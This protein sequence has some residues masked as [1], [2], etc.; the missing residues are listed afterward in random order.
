MARAALTMPDAVAL[1]YIAEVHG[2]GI[3]ICCS[4]L[5]PLHRALYACKDE[6]RYTFEVYERSAS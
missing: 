6:E 1:G 3:D 2:P 4:R 5:P